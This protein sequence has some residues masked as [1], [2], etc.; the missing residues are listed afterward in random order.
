MKKIALL[1]MLACVALTGCKTDDEDDIKTVTPEE[2]P[3]YDGLSLN[4]V[5][6]KQSPDDDWVE[7]YNSSEKDIRLDGCVLVKTDEN[8]EDKV[9][10]TAPADKSIKAGEHLVIATLTG[11]LQAGISNSKQVAIDLQTPEGQSLSKFDRDADV[12]KDNGHK[13]GGSYARKP[14]GTGAWTITTAATRGKANQ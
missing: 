10:Y 9:I 2:M 8:G 5:C 6:G 11:E 14:D 1:L 3:A 7:L 4:E 12:G 13:E